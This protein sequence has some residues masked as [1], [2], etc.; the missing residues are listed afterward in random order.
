MNRSQA[1][2][3]SLLAGLVILAFIGLGFVLLFPVEQI[4]ISPPTPTAPSSPTATVTPT[5][6]SF[7]PTPDLSSPTPAEPTATN[8][9]VPTAT[10]A[11]TETPVP[12]V[13]IV[14]PR[15]TIKPTVTPTRPVSIRP[16]LSPTPGN[17]EPTPTIGPLRYSISFEAEDTTL[18]KGDCTDL[19]WRVDGPVQVALEGESVALTGRKKVCPE[20][21]TSYEL[22][23]QIVGNPQIDRRSIDIQVEEDND[24]NNNSDDE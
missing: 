13:N 23:T 3:I 22:T 9:R 17:V 20:K 7:L 11:P 10:P 5:F 16:V 1:T 14:L 4:W 18:D 12:T 2:I 8:T 6:P 15:P 21:N 19:V 24:N